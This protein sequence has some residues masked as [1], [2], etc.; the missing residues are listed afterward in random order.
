MLEVFLSI[1][2]WGSGLQL[3]SYEGS[4]SF[5]ACNL[6]LLMSQ[7]RQKGLFYLYY[8]KTRFWRDL[9]TG[10]IHC[11]WHVKYIWHGDDEMNMYISIPKIGIYSCIYLFIAMFS[12]GVTMLQQSFKLAHPLRRMRGT[13]CICWS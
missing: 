4:C 2:S 8:S 3:W 5:R 13:Y 6:Y 12:I 7:H 11:M 9:C 1:I 10:D